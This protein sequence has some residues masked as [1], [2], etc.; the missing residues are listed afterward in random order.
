[1]V[2]FRVTALNLAKKDVVQAP[3]VLL[4]LNI[5]IFK[6]MEVMIEGSE[7]SKD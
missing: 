3:S 7:D 1:M 2:T 4:N 5:M 6:K